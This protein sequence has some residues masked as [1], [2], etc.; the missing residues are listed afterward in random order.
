M[1]ASN[2]LVCRIRQFGVDRG[3]TLRELVDAAT[4]EGIDFQEI[5]AVAKRGAAS[6]EDEAFGPTYYLRL[7]RVRG[8]DKVLIRIYLRMELELPDA[9]FIV[10]PVAT[11]SVGRSDERLT[12]K[13]VMN[14][15]ANEVGI[16]VLLP[17]MR[18]AL[19]DVSGRVLGEPL[20]MPI[21]Q[22]GQLV[23][24]EADLVESAQ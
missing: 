20:L 2:G 18:Q 9:H 3:E 6:R 11:Y 21:L 4:L 16:M 12:E 22:R 24:D 19:A 23:F 10:E 14:D 1:S 15:F 13:G 5:A 8:D 7:D 17:Y